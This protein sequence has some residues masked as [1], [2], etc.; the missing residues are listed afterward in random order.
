MHCASSGVL[1]P[2]ERINCL[3]IGYTAPYLTSILSA[4]ALEQYESISQYLSRKW[5][6]D[7]ALRTQLREMKACLDKLETSI[8]QIERLSNHQNQLLTL[9]IEARA[10]QNVHDAAFLASE[11][12]SDFESLLL[13]RR[14]ALDRLTNFISRQYGNYTDRF[15]RLEHTTKF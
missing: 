7:P 14:A 5:D 13:Q 15:S 8:L 2:P 9:A 1:I 6:E 3:A 12:S 11:V 4:T 10:K